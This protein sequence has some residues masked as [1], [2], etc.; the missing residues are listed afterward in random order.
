MA[1]L[2]V[3]LGLAIML[4]GIRVMSCGLSRAVG[5][6]MRGLLHH[7][8]RTPLV[9]FLT[10]IVAAAAAQSSSLVTVLLVG[11]VD[12]GLLDYAQAF[13]IM[14]GANVGTTFTLQLLAL[15]RDSYALPLFCAGLALVAFFRRGYLY[16]LGCIFLGSGSIFLGFSLTSMACAGIEH[17]PSFRNWLAQRAHDPYYGLM[18]G[19]VVTG[20][21]Q[22][23]SAVMGMVAAMAREGLVSLHLAVSI[24]LGANVGTCVTSLLTSLGTGVA[25]R[26]TAVAHLLFNILGAAALFPLLPWFVPMVAATSLDPALQTANAHTIFNVVTALFALPLTS[27]FVSL[28]LRLV[29]DK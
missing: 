26:R 23:S 3:F 10:G 27:W 24:C 22:S 16:Y 25:G 6:R 12:A 7:L 9:G 18:L 8:T 4:V 2:L 21:I 17:E 5:P 20:I 1:V 11:M 19:C 29:P 13:S 28:V 14:L 15:S